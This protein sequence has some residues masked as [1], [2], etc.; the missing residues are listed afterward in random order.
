MANSDWVA[1]FGCVLNNFWILK[2]FVPKK[3][4]FK[5]KI[6]FLSRNLLPINLNSKSSNNSLI[7]SK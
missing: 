1:I 5:N 6:P 2:A 4:Y 3:K 7:I